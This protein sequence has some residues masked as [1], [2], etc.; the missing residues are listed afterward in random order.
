MASGTGKRPEQRRTVQIRT[1][2]FPKDLPALKNLFSEGRVFQTDETS[3]SYRSG[4]GKR[5]C[6]LEDAGCVLFISLLK[7]FLN[8]LGSRKTA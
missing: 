1:A 3:Y 4:R 2:G 7:P 5:F 6:L 8:L